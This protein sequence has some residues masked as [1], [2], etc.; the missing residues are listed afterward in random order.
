V[1]DLER[2]ING[3]W[4]ARDTLSPETRGTIRE[5]VETALEQLDSGPEGIR[6]LEWRRNDS[7]TTFFSHW[8]VIQSPSIF[9]ATRT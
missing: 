7:R 4:E 8:C 3:A 1:S 5:A 2:I 9:S 6:R